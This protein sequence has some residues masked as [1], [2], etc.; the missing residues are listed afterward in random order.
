[1]ILE[2]HK[3]LFVTQESTDKEFTRRSHNGSLNQSSDR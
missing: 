3:R 2:N 1:M